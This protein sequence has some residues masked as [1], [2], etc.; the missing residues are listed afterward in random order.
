M[1]TTDA[2][3]I[4]NLCQELFP[5]LTSVSDVVLL[6]WASKA[7]ANLD[8]DAYGDMYLYGLCYAT[9]HE[10]TMFKDAVTFGAS[11]SGPVQSKRAGN[12]GITFVGSSVSADSPAAYWSQTVYGRALQTLRKE[13]AASHAF[14]VG[15]SGA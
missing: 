10:Y 14:I 15:P 11:A 7:I 4:V 3:T 2:Q 9:A 12:V 5:A 8:V 6:P 1:S 13:R